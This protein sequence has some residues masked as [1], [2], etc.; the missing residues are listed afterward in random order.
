[1]IYMTIGTTANAHVND[2]TYQCIIARRH[3]VPMQWCDV[4]TSVACGGV[5]SELYT[6]IYI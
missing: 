2:G 3:V 5:Y 6:L 1:M 4:D